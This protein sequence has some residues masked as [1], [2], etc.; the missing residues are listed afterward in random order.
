MFMT[1]MALDPQR[2]ETQRALA[3]PIM[4]HRAVQEA[5]DSPGCLTP[6]R[7]EQVQHRTYLLMVSV[8][9]PS[10]LQLHE[11]YGVLGAFPSWE[12]KNYD[13]L[14]DAAEAGTQ[15]RF[16]LCACPQCISC[17]QDEMHLRLH[18]MTLRT[19]S[20]LKQWLMEQAPG[21]GFQVEEDAL[22][23]VR[24]GW[25]VVSPSAPGGTEALLC[26]QVQYEGLLR[27]E[28]QAAFRRTLTEGIGPCRAWGMGL[29]TVMRPGG[30]LHV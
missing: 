2:P 25:Q 20:A 9:R 23:V 18:A 27:V 11:Q 24:S 6:W 15:W 1:R 22:N 29:L 14:L 19:T 8:Y 7:I 21:G 26:Q 4:L 13:D 17:A 10:M 5:A 16:S 30:V 3:S 12:S 28:K